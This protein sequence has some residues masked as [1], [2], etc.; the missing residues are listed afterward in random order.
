LTNWASD[1]RVADWA[2][3]VET[4]TADMM[5][6]NA[7]KKVFMRSLRGKKFDAP[8]MLKLFFIHKLQFRNHGRLTRI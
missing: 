4:T 3:A 1:N 6:T 8:S 2:L 7:I 5:A